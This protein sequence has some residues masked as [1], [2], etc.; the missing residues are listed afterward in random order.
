MKESKYSN[1][2]ND[3][4]IKDIIVI[5]KNLR[6]TELNNLYNLD[7][8]AS[9][10][11]AEGFNLTPLEATSSGTPIIV[12]KESAAIILTRALVYK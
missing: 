1:L 10:Y 8:Y 3:K 4:N 6:I 11:R 2:I 9:P 7:C 12:T 5:S